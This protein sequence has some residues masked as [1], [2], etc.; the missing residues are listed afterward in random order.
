MADEEDMPQLD[1]LKEAKTLGK[2]LNGSLKSK[3]ALL[4]ALKVRWYIG[5]SAKAI[6]AGCLSV[7]VQR[8]HK[9]SFKR[10]KIL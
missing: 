10:I 9:D 6:Q 2:V 7:R 8:L 1:V 4:K 3:D 5:L